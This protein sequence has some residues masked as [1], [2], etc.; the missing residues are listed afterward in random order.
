VALLRVLQEREFERVGGGAAIRAD[1]RVI[2]ATHRNLPELIDA[3]SFRSDL[4]YRI[5]VFPIEVPAL[6]DRKEDI[7]L[8]VAYFIERYSTKSGKKFLS[9]SKKSMDSFEA[10]AWP[11]NIRELQNVIERSVIVCDSDEFSVDQSWL[12]RAPATSARPLVEDPWMKNERAL[13]R[14]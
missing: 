1:V 14:R 9:I 10:Y 2:A 3:G 12:S 5:N 6:R 11:G 7:R 4:Y 13:K 8:L